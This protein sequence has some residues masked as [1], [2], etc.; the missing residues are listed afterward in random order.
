MTVDFDIENLTAAT[1]GD[2]KPDMSLEKLKNYF[3]NES[4]EKMTCTIK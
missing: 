3:E 1:D 4:T 2:L